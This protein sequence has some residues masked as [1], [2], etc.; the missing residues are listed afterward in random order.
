MIETIVGGSGR[1]VIA[2]D[3]AVGL[4]SSLWNKA[5]EAVLQAGHQHVA[6]GAMSPEDPAG[7]PLHHGHRV[8]RP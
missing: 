6:E 7:D 1:D 5:Q 3:L 4:Q 2:G 8:D